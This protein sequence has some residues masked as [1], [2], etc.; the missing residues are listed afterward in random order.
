[1]LGLSGYGS[2]GSSSSDDEGEGQ[3]SGLLPGLGAYRSS[4]TT[5]AAT[6][7]KSV[8]AAA[9][10]NKDK[11]LKVKSTASPV[12]KKRPA[13]TNAKLIAKQDDVKPQTPDTAADDD[14]AVLTSEERQTRTERMLRHG[15]AIGISKEVLLEAQ[16]KLPKR[17]QGECAP[18]A[19][20][21]YRSYVAT[22]ES[23]G[24]GGNFVEQ[25]VK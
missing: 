6:A 23:M 17:S 15:Q 5:A 21:S 4:K 19:L 10:Q 13:P 22:A 2:S 12:T 7:S 9:A 1:M 3:T 20:A 11:E 25:Q 16:R 14:A 8:D 18:A 24:E